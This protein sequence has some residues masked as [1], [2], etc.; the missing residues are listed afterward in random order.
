MSPN[1]IHLIPLFL[2]FHSSPTP[3]QGSSTSWCTTSPSAS[4]SASPSSSKSFLTQPAALQPTQPLPTPQFSHLPGKFNQLVYNFP[5]R[6]PERFSL[7]IRSLLTQEG[8]C[9]SLEP[10][11]KFLEVAYPYV[12]KRLLTDPDPALR[13]RLIQVCTHVAPPVLVVCETSHN[14]LLTQ[15][16]ICLSLEPNFK[17]LEVAYPY[18]AKRLLSDPALRSRLIQVRTCSLHSGDF[19]RLTTR[20][21]PRRASA[22]PSN[23]TLSSFLEVAYPYVAKRLLT[24][25]DPALRSRLIQVCTG[26]THPAA[27]TVASHSSLFTQEG[28]CLSLEPNFKFLEVAYPYVAKRLLTDPHPALR[29]RLIQ[30]RAHVAPRSLGGT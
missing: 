24:D 2:P 4:P 23:P 30:V 9:L 14:S 15:E 5:I 13:S 22:S 17:F 12:A 19:T 10:N 21:S 29:S 26:S 27:S 20:C 8:I 28:I 25:P 1:P 3:V 11:F 18:V 7:V 16:G 6:I